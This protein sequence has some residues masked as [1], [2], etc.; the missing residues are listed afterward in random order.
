VAQRVAIEEG[1]YFKGKVDIQKDL[2]KTEGTKVDGAKTEAA[3]TTLPMS[4]SA[5]ASAASAGGSSPVT[6]KTTPG[7]GR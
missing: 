1:A 7:D 6:A 5:G 2:A 4:S 3:K